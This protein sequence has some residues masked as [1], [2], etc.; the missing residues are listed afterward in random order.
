MVIH[1]LTKIILYL[2]SFYC[3]LIQFFYINESWYP[4]VAK[5]VNN[6]ISLIE[7][8]IHGFINPL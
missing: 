3:L 5:E 1:Q 6:V 7:K 4:N 2:L 8:K